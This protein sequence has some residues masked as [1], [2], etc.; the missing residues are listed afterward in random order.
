MT[1]SEGVKM[2][3]ELGAAA[4]LECSAMQVCLDSAFFFLFIM[5]KE[6]DRIDKIKK[7]SVKSDIQKQR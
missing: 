1:Y 7:K 2:A 5:K 4:Y 6:T 3:K